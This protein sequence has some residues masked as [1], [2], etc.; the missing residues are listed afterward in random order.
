LKVILGFHSNFWALG[1][2][3]IPT[4]AASGQVRNVKDAFPSKHRG[5]KLGENPI[6]GYPS[7]MLTESSIQYVSQ[8][9]TSPQRGGVY[10]FQKVGRS[11]V[12]YGT[13][14]IHKYPAKF[15][16]LIPRW[17]LSYDPETPSRTVMDPFCGSGTTLVEAGLLGATSY[18][19][20]ISPLAVLLTSAKC[21]IISNEEA[22]QWL[23]YLESVLKRSTTLAPKLEVELRSQ[24]NSDALGLHRTWSNWF[25]PREA[26]KLVAIRQAIIA[27]KL[28]PT[29]NRIALASLSA[30]TKS[31]SRLHEDQIKV[32]FDH[33]K[34][35]ADPFEVFPKIFTKFV[36][37]QL[38]LSD[39]YGQANASFHIEQGTASS[40]GARANSID[41]VI[42]S[43]P[44]INAVD[45]TMAHKYNMFVLGLLEPDRFKEHCREYIGVTERAVRASDISSTPVVLTKSA[46]SAVRRIE[47]TK[48]PAA[49]N[50]AYVVA[51]YFSGM[52]NSLQEAFRVLRKRGLMFLVVGES[53]RICGI[54]VETA[55]ILGDAAKMAGFKVELEFLHA[56]A[57]RSSMRLGRS[58]SGGKI[59]HERVY[60]LRK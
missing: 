15:I 13:H 58:R 11:D 7:G 28:S 14:G 39:S 54:T 53:N 55:G 52:E 19:I 3:A 2:L 34:D 27:R 42:T 20:D 21:S 40:T 23:A 26:A 38:L 57:N 10:S 50:R 51:Q 37:S 30:V 9:P 16:P 12:T 35:V 32:R 49:R 47:A 5:L 44:Y 60:V 31:C 6:S 46:M 1:G 36:Q 18:G 25:T 4:V 24:L 22:K 56:L 45:Y 43:P 59:A 33:T 17:A 29:L 8:L 41:R 48:K